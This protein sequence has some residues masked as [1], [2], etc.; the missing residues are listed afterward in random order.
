MPPIKINKQELEEFRNWKKKKEELP[1]EEPKKEEIKKAPDPTLINPKEELKK[2][3]PKDLEIEPEP[4]SEN[5][6][7]A[8]KKENEEKE[9]DG[10]EYDCG[11]CGHKQISKEK[12][13]GC[14]KCG[15]SFDWGE[16]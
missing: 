15:A 2:E 12:L 6:Q 8:I 14:S 4:I 11:K 16:E 3:D 7:K 1:A 9:D 5:M 13:N 10:Y